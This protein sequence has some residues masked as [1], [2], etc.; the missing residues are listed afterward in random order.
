MVKSKSTGKKFK[1]NPL[2]ARPSPRDIPVVTQGSRTIPYDHIWVKYAYSTRA[3]SAMEAYFRQHEEYTHLVICPDDLIVKGEHI[4]A[5]KQVLE[6]HDYPVL[7]GISNI[8]PAMPGFISTCR[9]KLPTPF[10][11]G[12]VYEL[13]TDEEAAEANGVIEVKWTGW[14]AGFIARRVFDKIHLESDNALNK[15]PER[16][17]GQ[18]FDLMFCWNCEKH[19][20]PIYVDTRVRMLHLKGMPE[21]KDFLTIQVNKKKPYI[22]VDKQGHNPIIYKLTMPEDSLLGVYER[23]KGGAYDTNQATLLEKIVKEIEGIKRKIN[24][25]EDIEYD[26]VNEVRELPSN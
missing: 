4:E 5:L 25:I 10:R 14:P 11:P 9:Y 6:E 22:L 24:L 12:R 23:C 8:T 18:A 21:Y 13:M 19:E 20:I 1:V 17:M 15:S 26:F 2:I 7:A 3:Y 16:E